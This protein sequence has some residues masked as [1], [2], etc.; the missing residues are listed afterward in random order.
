MRRRAQLHR[1]VDGAHQFLEPLI[2]DRVVNLD[3]WQRGDADRLAMP[4]RSPAGDGEPHRTSPGEK[5][6]RPGNDVEP[7]AVSAGA[8]RAHVQRPRGGRPVRRGDRHDG[9]ERHV[10]RPAVGSRPERGANQVPAGVRVDDQP[11]EPRR[12]GE[13]PQAAADLGGRLEGALDPGFPA[14]RG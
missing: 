12:L 6:D 10:D 14:V 5:V 11:V 3:E 2:V 8:E 1:D 9:V 13:E 7:L 4:R